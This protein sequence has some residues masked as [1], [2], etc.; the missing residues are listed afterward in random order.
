MEAAFVDAIGF[1]VIDAG[2]LAEGRAFRPGSTVHN[3]YGR[4]LD[5]AT[6]RAGLG[7]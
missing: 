7:L 2:P 1:D 5:A 4:A 3:V 6:P